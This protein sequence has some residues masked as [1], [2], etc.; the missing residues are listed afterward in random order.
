MAKLNKTEETTLQLAEVQGLLDAEKNE[1]ASTRNALDL[2]AAALLDEQAAHSSTRG[3]LEAALQRSETSAEPLPDG[4]AVA[5]VI[6]DEG[7]MLAQ[8]SGFLMDIPDDSNLKRAVFAFLDC[9]VENYK[10]GPGQPGRNALA[11]LTALSDSTDSCYKSMTVLQR[12]SSVAAANSL[13]GAFK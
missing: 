4:E 8:L 3:L 5:S 2:N 13:K 1:H 10:D 7:Q 6:A 12:A 9:L 11:I